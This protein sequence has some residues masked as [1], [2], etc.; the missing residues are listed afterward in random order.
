MALHPYAT[1][2]APD[3]R[4]FTIYNNGD[5]AQFISHRRSLLTEAERDLLDRCDKTAQASF[6]PLPK[7]ARCPAKPR[8]PLYA[9]KPYNEEGS[10]A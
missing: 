10:Q 6:K 5:L 1:M 2:T 7:F 3:G 4:A 8:M 9:L